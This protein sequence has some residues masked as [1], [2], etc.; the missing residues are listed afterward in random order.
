MLIG[1]IRRHSVLIPLG[2]RVMNEFLNVGFRIVDIIVKI[3]HQ[4]KSTKFYEG[5]E[6]AHYLLQHEYLLIFQK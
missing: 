3:Q 2:L 6:F 4:D 1:D 5:K